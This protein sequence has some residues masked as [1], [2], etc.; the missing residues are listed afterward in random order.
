MLFYLRFIIIII[1]IIIIINIKT[2]GHGPSG[3][4]EIVYKFATLQASVLRKNEKTQLMAVTN[5]LT[6]PLNPS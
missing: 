5:G 3:K 4:S 1:I 2:S 6:A